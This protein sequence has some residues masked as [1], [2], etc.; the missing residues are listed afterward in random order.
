MNYTITHQQWLKAKADYR[1][2]WNC[3]TD[4]S[5]SCNAAVANFMF[6]GHGI[7]NVNLKNGSLMRIL[8]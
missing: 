5:S 4:K 7:L 2:R 1:K 6:T 3:K 8:F